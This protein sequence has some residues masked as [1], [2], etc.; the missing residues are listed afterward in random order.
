MATN[1][2]VQVPPDSTGKK[3]ATRQHTLDAQIVE[4]QLLHI[5]SGDNAANA[6]SIDNKG[7]AQVRFT[8][9]QAIVSSY[10]S[11]K[12]ES[13]RQLGVYDS[14]IDTY[15]D[16][17][18][19]ELVGS[20][21]STYDAVK[22][23]IVLAVGTDSGAS[24]TRTTNRYHY[25]LPGTSNLLRIS[26]A[27]GD[28]GKA[29]VK[30]RWG[31]FDDNDGIFFE[32]NGTE[33]RAVIRASTTGVVTETP[34][35]R[36]AWTDKLDGTGLS[37]VTLDITKVNNYWADYT[38]SGAGRVRFGI[39]SPTGERIIAY[40]IQT[41]NAAPFPLIRTATLPTR[42]EVLNTGASGS[43][44]EL[45]EVA[46]SV[47]TEGNP[48]DYTFWRNAD[49]EVYGVTTVTDTHLVSVS[50]IATIN[51]KHNSVQA[52]PETLNVVV[53]GGPVAISLWQGTD[54]TSPTWVAGAGSLETSTA[55]T[56]G[57]SNARKILTFFA[58]VGVKTIELAKYFELN[59]EG[60]H[61][62]ADGTKEVW[63]LTATR[64]SGSTTTVGM[65]MPYRELW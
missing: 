34:V 10:G 6:L 58:D 29:N 37:G 13:E 64:L 1:S 41:G 55:G 65:N 52:Y 35:P 31:N 25:Y 12:I 24:V 26:V 48:S 51:S 59:D 36:A 4:S 49:I 17:M 42:T 3:L 15:D 5:V 38:F 16:L 22:S 44:S 18:S 32:L 56:L 33:I 14:T 63:S 23:S 11:L 39:Y 43:T 28:A 46:M 61:I 50:S 7:A 9:G 30:R 60:I 20:G 40:V 47:S 54:I 8:E 27:C 45:R 19:I 62:L 53:T 2:Y 57:Y 21:T